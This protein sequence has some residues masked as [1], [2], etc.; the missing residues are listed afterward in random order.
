MTATED[1]TLSREARFLWAKTG[2]GEEQHLYGLLQTHLADT[3]EVARAL[4]R[5]WLPEA[6]R[7]YIRQQLNLE[8]ELAEA[9]VVWL[10][11]IHDIGK[12]T[13]SFQSKVIGL[14]ERV[15]ETGLRIPIR[16]NNLPHAYLGELIVCDWLVD[17]GWDEK[18][19]KGF[20][21]VVGGHHGRNPSK[22]ELKDIRFGIQL[23]PDRTLGAAAWKI[24]QSELSSWTFES[25][26][27]GR[28]EAQ[29][30]E[31]RLPRYIQVLLTGIVIMADWIASNTELFP[32]LGAY[33]SW[34]DCMR[35]ADDAWAMLDLPERL[36]LVSLPEDPAALFSTRFPGIPLGAELRPIQHEAAVAAQELEEP[37]LIIVEAPMGE[38]KTEASLLCAELIAKRFACGG[39]AYLL[40]T[41][42]TS[43]AMF[44][45]VH[46]WLGSLLESQPVTKIQDIHLLHGKAE[47][48]EEFSSLSRWPS[49]WMGDECGEEEAIIAHQWFSGRKRGL[50]APFVVGTVDQLLMAALKTKHAH[51]RHLGLSGKV[52]VI[53]E[54]HAYDAY[55]SVYL[56][57][58]LEFLGAYH[59]PTIILSATL[60][61]SRRKQLIQAYRGH[62]KHGSRRK[63]HV[64]EAPR[65]VSGSPAYPL[66]TTSSAC[67]NEP[68]VYKAVKGSGR[69]TKVLLE[70]LPDDDELLVSTLEELLEDGGCVCV[71]RDTVFRAQNTYQLLKSRFS[72]DV[73]LLHARFTAIDRVTREESLV[74]ELGASSNQRPKALVVVA[75]QVVEQSLDLDFDL[76]ITDIAPVDLLLQRMGRL[77]R[78]PRG[79]GECER[80]ARLR[81]A[82]CIVTGVDDWNKDLPRF[83]RGI[84]RVYQPAVLWRSIVALRALGN[85]D[86]GI[87][88]PQDIAP[89]VERVY[90]GL[91]AIEDEAFE[92]ACHAID[93][94]VSGK[95]RSAKAYLLGSLGNKRYLTLDGWMDG[96]LSLEGEI[97]GKAAVRDTAES[98]EVIAVQQTDKGYE[99]LPWVADYLGIDPKL[100]TGQEEPSN[101]SARAAALC[102]VN[103]PLLMS[104]PNVIEEVI[105]ALEQSGT[106]EGWQRSHWLAGTLPL[107][108]NKHGEAIVRCE[109]K[110][111]QVK[112]TRE[113]GLEASIERRVG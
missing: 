82:R 91:D 98:I 60:P 56:D 101:E 15:R 106:F 67:D 31:V 59:V 103:L 57:R 89:L 85:E 26:G 76:L 94:E 54:V 33:A 41:Q 19:A 9:L 10:A 49:S 79:Q 27:A 14:A 34:D 38:G 81:Q 39:M 11:A 83:S 99:V 48:N 80:P 17:K 90:E 55:M 18:N 40:P 64:P 21:S 20:A 4:W 46:N 6:T 78:H 84:D 30:K 110:E 74:R 51:L 12:A 112:Y 65:L 96:P 36:E 24:V 43:N 35:R 5:S 3:A 71:L 72:V 16:C 7:Q 88:L 113:M 28:F 37:G 69:N 29:L 32:L 58:V 111:F 42:A 102:A 44:A 61:P 100:G 13:P 97:Q 63:Y 50:L 73:R 87:N 45:R 75:T 93:M 2:R 105:R 66:I 25:S 77:H 22:M 95:E 23:E 92:D 8:D 68:L 53:D 47:L 108:L 104:L 62:S 1:E 52:V 86:E 70:Y 109:D 107:I